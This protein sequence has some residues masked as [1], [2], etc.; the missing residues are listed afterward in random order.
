MD[1]ICGIYCIEN[2]VNH[3]KYV[4]QSIDV[5]ARF[6]KHKSQ[7][8]N[9]IHNNLHLQSAWNFYG[10]NN[11]K[12]YVIEKCLESDLDEREIYYI[13]CMN[14]V[15]ENFGYNIESGG[16]KN[17]HMSER[18]KLKISH[19]LSGRIFTEEHRNK[20]SEANRNRLVSG[21]TRKKMSE[22]HA[23]FSGENNPRYGSHCTN[24]T[25]RKIVDN[26]KH[27]SGEN[28][29]NYGKCLSDETKRKMRDAKIG[30]YDGEKHPRCRPVYC[31]ELNKKF[32][33]AKEAELELGID[34]TYI[35]ACLNGKQ[36]S[37]GKHPITGERLHW[38][39]ANEII[40]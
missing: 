35:S 11:F 37:A 7:L 12:F 36:K 4:G 3:K 26:R 17:K 21:I 29:P 34:S 16:T 10:E 23:D 6:R 5:M 24:E 9:N 19:S 22:N 30:K 33:G 14:T 39:D 15:D 31:P 27:L 13:S 20:I 18:S 28:H 25:K 1:R 32:W 8:Y 2:L 38:L 40:A